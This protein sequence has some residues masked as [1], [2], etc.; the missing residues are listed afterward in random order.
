MGLI[1][2]GH[3]LGGALGAFMGGYLFDQFNSYAA[4]WIFAVTT[5]AG[6][7]AMVLLLRDEREFNWFKPRFASSA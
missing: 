1:T 3:A 6:A 5:L 7:A 4:T 2:G